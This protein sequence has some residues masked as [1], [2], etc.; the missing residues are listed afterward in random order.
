MHNRAFLIDI[1]LMA[2]LALNDEHR[3]VEK[4]REA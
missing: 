4:E 3:M 1:F 2:L